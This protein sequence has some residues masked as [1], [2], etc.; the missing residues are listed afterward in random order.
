[1]SHHYSGP[2]FGFPRGDARLDFT[3]LYAF[4]KPG[5]ASKSILIMNAHPSAVVN[6]PGP[7]TAE[8]FASEARYELKIDTNG[9]AVADITYRVCFSSSEDGT[10]TATLRRVD[11]TQAP[12]TG[13]DGQII[14]EGV[15]VSTERD[16]RVTQAG[17]RNCRRRCTRKRRQKPAIA[18]TPCTTRS[19]ART[20]WSMP[21]PSAAPT[22]AHRAW[23]VRSSRTSRRMG[24]SDGSAN[25]RSALRQE[26][27]RPAPIRRVFI[28]KANGKLR[29]LGIDLAGSGRMTAAMLVLELIFEA[30]LPPEQYA[31]RPGRNAATGGGRGGRRC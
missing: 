22:R 30:D 6:P 31:Y 12:A 14:V 15:P 21:M 7:T 4:S 28:P 8:P 5:D 29:P 11:G 25:L 18:S 19:A 13:D 23:M 2:N 9:D 27:Y 10:Q 3:D 20:S 17:D 26:T 24:C 1:M 16:A